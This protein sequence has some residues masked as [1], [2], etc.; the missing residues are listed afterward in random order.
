M[1]RSR[2]GRGEGSLYQRSDGLWVASISAG[3]GTTGKRRRLVAY[4]AT[5]QQ[6]QDKLRGL[7]ARDV[8]QID[9]GK[10]LLRDLV[11][12][13]LDS[14][15][16]TVGTSTFPRYQQLA[17]T[18]VVP[19]LGH[20]KASELVP[21]HVEQFYAALA[22]DGISAAT[23]VKAGTVLGYV[24][25][26]AVKMRFLPHNVASDVRKPK[27]EAPQMKVLSPEEVI[28]FLDEAQMDALH[29]L[30]V[31]ALATGMRSGELF[32]LQWADIDFANKS[33]HVTKTL[34]ELDGKHRVKHPKTPHS[35]RRIDLPEFALD[36]LHEHRKTMV[37]AGFGKSP[38]F[39]DSRGRYLR[40]ANVARR[41]LQPLLTKADC[42]RIRFHDLRHTNA[43]LLLVAGV[44]PKIVS[45]RLGH[46][47][48]EITLNTYSHVLPTMQRDAAEKLHLLIG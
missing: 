22:K 6:A 37:A 20:I 41:S 17:N 15:E 8:K 3:R 33:I 10:T 29:A 47:S 43:T 24:L 30:Y 16:R 26:F 5:K 28:R 32:A 38:V 14:V 11:A 21:L 44:N 39:C 7:Q 25:K 13:W 27:H 36:V 35:R 46:K 9:A 45:E 48:I 1:A 4:G 40:R 12:I 34:E 19:H 42:Q 31:V 18:Y 23:Q 2:R